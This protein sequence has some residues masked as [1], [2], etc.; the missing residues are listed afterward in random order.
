MYT[1]ARASECVR[2]LVIWL[3]LALTKLEAL[4][5]WPQGKTCGGEIGNRQFFSAGRAVLFGIWRCVKR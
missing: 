1:I 3:A 2:H 4:E 5:T